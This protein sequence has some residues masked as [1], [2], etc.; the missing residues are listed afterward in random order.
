M[1]EVEGGR[2]RSTWPTEDRLGGNPHLE[3]MFMSTAMKLGP[4]MRIRVE[5]GTLLW[6]RLGGGAMGAR[7]HVEMVDKGA[8]EDPEG[9]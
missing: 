1:V 7:W 5:K 9:V 6:F 4:R 3:P 8:S 2:R